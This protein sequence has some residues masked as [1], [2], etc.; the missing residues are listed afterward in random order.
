[1][2]EFAKISI[3]SAGKESEYITTGIETIDENIGG[4]PLHCVIVIKGHKKPLRD[5][6]LELYMSLQTQ[7]NDLC[8]WIRLKKFTCWDMLF[9]DIKEA[10][11]CNKKIII[12]EVRCMAIPNIFAADDVSRKLA[13]ELHKIVYET[14]IALILTKCFCNFLQIDKN[15]IDDIDNLAELIF[16]EREDGMGFDCI[17]NRETSV[18]FGINFPK[19]YT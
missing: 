1:M 14:G 13:E 9:K 3:D 16:R 18:M 8:I 19:K 17:K 10:V 4:L 6:L 11:S 12:L 2:T 5:S 7:Y 15:G